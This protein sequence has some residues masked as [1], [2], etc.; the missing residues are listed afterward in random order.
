MNT[1]NRFSVLPL[2]TLALVS[3]L[4]CGSVQAGTVACDASTLALVTNTTDCERSTSAT[5]D[6]LNTDPITV[7]AEEFFSFDDWLFLDK[8]EYDDNS[9][10]SGNWAVDASVW[11]NYS[12]LMLIFKDGAGTTLVGYLAADGATGG[13]WES[14]FREPEFDMKPDDKIKDVSHISYYVR[15]AVTRVPDTGSIILMLIGLA[16]LGLSR[17]RT[18]QTE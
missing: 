1:W 14:P 9:G 17:A 4:V 12:N 10:Q 5:Q 16:F 15:G 6:F 18:T 8:D 7:N 11:D 3:A 13:T 2:A